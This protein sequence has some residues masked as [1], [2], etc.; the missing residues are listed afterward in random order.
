MAPAGSRVKPPVT[1]A[2]G[3]GAPLTVDEG[4]S[5]ATRAPRPP[6]AAIVSSTSAAA[7]TSV[8]GAP[9]AK[10]RASMPFAATRATARV[11]S[12]ISACPTTP[13]VPRPTVARAFTA[14]SGSRPC[15]STW[16][17]AGSPSGHSDHSARRHSGRADGTSTTASTRLPSSVASASTASSPTVPRQSRDA[18]RSPPPGAGCAKRASSSPRVTSPRGGPR[19]TTCACVSSSSSAPGTTRTAAAASSTS[20][21]MGGAPGGVPWACT[22]P[23]RP[24]GIVRRTPGPPGGEGAFGF[25]GAKARASPRPPL[26]SASSATSTEPMVSGSM[27]TITSPPTAS[28]RTSPHVATLA[29]APVTRR[30]VRPPGSSTCASRPP[31][32]DTPRLPMR[33]IT[34][35]PANDGA[36]ASF[37]LA[38]TA[39]FT[40]GR[41]RCAIAPPESAATN[42]AATP[43]VRSA[44]P[45]P[46]RT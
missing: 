43:S 46:R 41:S 3:T 4:T 17:D 7:E 26:A 1:V 42:T 5:S 18:R 20:A 14:T 33:S 30:T 25:A 40:A 45:V 34:M 22:C 36:S 15:A 23:R 8:S 13:T 39:R 21:S 35:R 24:P 19:T 44:D 12:P 38:T 37:T 11:R 28:D 6:S 10:A 2:A 31:A 29:L 32:C 16:A 9:A 27:S